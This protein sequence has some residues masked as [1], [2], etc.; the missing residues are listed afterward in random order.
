MKF[1]NPLDNI[2]VASPCPANWDAMFGDDRKRFC[3]DC[4][5][6]VYNLSD[7]TRTAAE[8]L[9]QNSEGRLCVRFFRRAD[10]TILTKNCPVGWQA[11]KRRVSRVATTAFSMIAGLFGGIFAFNLLKERPQNAEVNLVTTQARYIQGDVATTPL[12]SGSVAIMGGAPVGEM[13]L[14]QRIISKNPSEK[15]KRQSK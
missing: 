12:S 15:I 9:I 10:G 5:L 7:M 2:S 6:H 3:G 11:V 8:N 13:I 4:K 1:T 14:G